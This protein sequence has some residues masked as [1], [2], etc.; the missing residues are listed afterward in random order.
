[1]CNH[2]YAEGR[3]VTCGVANCMRITG[4]L[5]DVTSQPVNKHQ[6]KQNIYYNT[7]NYVKVASNTSP[8]T[9]QFEC[10]WRSLCLLQLRPITVHTL[11]WITSHFYFFFNISQPLMFDTPWRSRW[12]LFELPTE[13]QRHNILQLSVL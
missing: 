6:V 11:L 12:S 8:S 10:Y 9:T 3:R 4:Q 5:K 7:S 2:S 1:M 13:I